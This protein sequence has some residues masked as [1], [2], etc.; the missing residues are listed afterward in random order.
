MTI[1]VRDI[2][3][4]SPWYTSKLGLRKLAE[5]PY[6]DSGTE[7]YSF[8]DDGDEVVLTTRSGFGTYP[9]PMLFTK[10]IGKMKEVLAA[11]GV[12]VGPI[13]RD[14]SGAQYFEMHDPEG[15]LIEVVER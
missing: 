15:N 9:T 4:V 13:N 1:R 5:N 11:R 10:K 2:S 6:G 7:S 14:A 3:S 12:E 8:K